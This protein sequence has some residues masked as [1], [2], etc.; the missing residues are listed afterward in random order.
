MNNTFQIVIQIKRERS[1]KA[2]KDLKIKFL[3]INTTTKDNTTFG[4]LD[5]EFVL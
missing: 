3:E 2:L 5:S 1:K 4:F